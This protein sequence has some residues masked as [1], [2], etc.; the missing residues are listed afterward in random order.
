MVPIA[1]INNDVHKILQVCM[2]FFSWWVSR[3][4]DI[5]FPFFV[6]FRIC[7]TTAELTLPLLL[8]AGSASYYN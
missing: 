1:R 5:F 8:L 3:Q 2:F 4:E 6:I 7:S